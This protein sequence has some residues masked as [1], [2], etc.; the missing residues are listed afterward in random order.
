MTQTQ[1]FIQ[2]FI[3]I[4]SE[5]G[6]KIQEINKM[7]SKIKDLNKIRD[8]RMDLGGRFFRPKPEIGNSGRFR[9]Q[10]F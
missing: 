4:Y 10:V 6:K 7:F 2:K 9:A 8:S 5:N 1:N 3:F